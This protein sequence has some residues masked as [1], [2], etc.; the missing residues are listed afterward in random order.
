MIQPF[1][2]TTSAAIMEQ[3]GL[4]AKYHLEELDLADLPTGVTV[5]AKGEPIFPRLDM[6][7]EIDY[8]KEQ[9]TMSIAKP[10]EADWDPEKVALNLKR[11]RLLLRLL[12]QLRFVWQRS[13]RCH[14]LK[15]LKNCCALD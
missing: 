4:G 2:M 15:A 8:I 9:M 14:E 12:M 3:L 10:Q 7:A 1:M 13:K 6:E 11:T 5:V